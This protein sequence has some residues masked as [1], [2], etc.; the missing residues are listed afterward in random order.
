[1]DG[2]IDVVD[3]GMQW[4]VVGYVVAAGPPLILTCSDQHG[5][6]MLTTLSLHRPTLHNHCLAQ[7]SP[8]A[9]TE[10]V[11]R[12]ENAFDINFRIRNDFIKR[13]G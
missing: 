13:S 10:L 12:I 9:P 5:L 7:A 1:M 11:A 3:C 8:R 4:L 6:R 2:W